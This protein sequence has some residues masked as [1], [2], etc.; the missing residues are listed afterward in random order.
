MPEKDPT[1]Y[2]LITY[3]W[4]TLLSA[5]GGVV[6][7]LSKLR[8][9]K[10]SRRFNL[11]EFIGEVTTSAFSGLL[12]FWGCEAAGFEPLWTAVLV[13]ISGHMGA[14]ALYQ[15]ELIVQRKLGVPTSGEPS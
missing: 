15:I 3:G 1:N 9:G 13:G 5:W 10:A 14:R 8:A 4:V 12:T 2:T 7:F 6:S 11:L